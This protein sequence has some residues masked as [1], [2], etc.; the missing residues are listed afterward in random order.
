VTL[1]VET[2]GVPAGTRV[3]FRVIVDDQMPSIPSKPR[4]VIAGRQAA[5]DIDPEGEP[6]LRPGVHRVT[7]QSVDGALAPATVAFSVQR[8]EGGLNPAF[9]IIAVVLIGFFIL[10]R[11]RVLRPVAD[12]MSGSEEQP[13]P[14][15][16]NG[17]GEEGD[18]RTV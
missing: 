4:T 9:L 18:D 7:V 17:W 13:P 11:T 1:V 12:R 8:G 3:P 15:G 6:K 5:L 16:S 10:Y 14:G 2:D